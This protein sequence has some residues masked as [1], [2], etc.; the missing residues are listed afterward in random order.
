MASQGL[1]SRP[2]GEGGPGRE[3]TPDSPLVVRLPKGKAGEGLVLPS[4]PA[5]GVLSRLVGEPWGGWSRL[6]P[7]PK[8]GGPEPKPPASCCLPG[9]SPLAPSQLSSSLSLLLSPQGRGSQPDCWS[10]WAPSLHPSL[11]DCWWVL[12][13]P[14]L[15]FLGASQPPRLP[16]QKF[17]V[18]K[19]LS[20]TSLVVSRRP[21]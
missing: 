5:E 11:T 1:V 19:S 13:F 17:L 9:P 20:V 2:R 8:K 6:A 10:H 12:W 3:G 18:S 14:R 15:R 7:R 16:I 21:R 4:G